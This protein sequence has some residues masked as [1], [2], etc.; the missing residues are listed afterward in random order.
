MATTLTKNA[1]TLTLPDH[2]DWPDEFAWSATQMRR[3]YSAGGALLLDAGTKLAGRPITLAGD[4]RHAWA[5]RA[6]ALTLQ[7]WTHDPIANMQLLFRGATYTVG[8]AAV[9]VPF[10]FTPKIN[11][12]TPVSTDL[13]Y[14]VL[15]LITL[16]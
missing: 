13:G 6:Q 11:Y 15:Q 3:S 9:D 4:A 12:S 16:A 2:L 14:F 8:F 7:E 5:Q 1:V 10:T